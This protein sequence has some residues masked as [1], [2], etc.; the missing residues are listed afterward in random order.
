MFSGIVEAVAPILKTQALSG[1]VRIQVAKPIFFDDLKI[2]DSIAVNGICLTVEAIIAK[3]DFKNYSIEFD[4]NK[5]TI[6]NNFNLLEF[7]GAIQ[8]AL[9][10]ETLKVLKWSPD[11]DLASKPVNLE[12]SLRFGDRI[13]GHLVSGHVEDL[14]EVVETNF[15]GESLI[16]RVCLPPSVLPFVWKKGS[17]TLNGVSLTINQLE[18]NKIEVCLIPETQKRTNLALLKKN[19]FINIEPDWMARALLRER[20]YHEERQN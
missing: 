16:L 5:K 14:G 15:S 19:D 10:T 13:H 6:P 4:E 8:F 9:A 1:L 2:G 3:A 7:D 17:I 18:Q 12:R 11:L 20:E